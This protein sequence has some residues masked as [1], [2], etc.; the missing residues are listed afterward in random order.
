M[1]EKCM[2]NSICIVEEFINAVE[3]GY[4]PSPDEVKYV[5]SL[6]GEP[7]KK[8]SVVKGRYIDVFTRL[9]QKNCIE[10]SNGELCIYSWNPRMYI[11]Y[12]PVSIDATGTI[13]YIGRDGSVETIA[14][15]IHR[16]HDIEGRRVKILD[17]KEYRVSEVTYRIDGYQITFY[18]N[19]FIKKWVPATKYLMHNMQYMGRQ[20]IVEDINEVINPRAYIAYELAK[21]IGLYDKIVKFSPKWTLTFILEPPEPAILKPNVEL[22]DISS[23]KLYLLTIRKPDGTLLTVSESKKILDLETVPIE[24]IELK[25][26][27]ELSEFIEKSKKI[28]HSRSVFIRY[29]SEDKHRP[30]TIEVKSKLYPEAMAVK[31]QSNPKSLL[32]LASYGYGVEAVNMLTEYHGIRDKG[33]QIISLY[34]RI[35]EY[36]KECIDK[37]EFDEIVNKIGLYKQL[38]GEIEKARRTKNVERLLRK[39][40]ALVSGDTIDE[41]LNN[42][43]ALL[44]S[45]KDKCL[46]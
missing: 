20:L 21:Q 38:R 46:K 13:L 37:P 31:Y 10:V 18:Y 42:L 15:P 16:S 11:R 6:L 1:F 5:G 33:Q 44:S 43:S 36:I 29:D 8:I 39:L 7:S 2:G 41:A 14:Y 24:S 32:I 22:Y 12:F 27:S 40:L 26:Y 45:L 19:P 25:S 28:L 23:F 4:E 30:Y 9:I 34:K 17:P 3:K 35:S